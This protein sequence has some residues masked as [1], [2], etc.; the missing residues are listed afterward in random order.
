MKRIALAASFA[1]IVV[2]A[3]APASAQSSATQLKTSH[4]GHA[5]YPQ[6]S[7]DGTSLAYEVLYPADKRREL[8]MVGFSGRSLS[9]DPEK[10]LP[11]SMASSSRYGGSKRVIHGF[12]WATTGNFRYAY[13]VSDNQGTQDIYVDNWS[14]MVESAGAANK[15]ADWD[16]T[17]ARFVF[18]SGRTGKGD[19]YLWDQGSELQLTYDER[20]GELYPK[21]S[22]DGTKVAFVRA[23]ASSSQIM[24]LDVNLFT[25][26]ALVPW[27]DSDST[28]PSFSPD[29]S[30]IA[31]FSNKGTDGVTKF[32]LWVTDA[33]PGGTPRNVG[34]AVKIPTKGAAHWTPDGKGIVAVLDDADKGDPV[35]IFPVDGGAPNCL[36]TGT[37][38]NRDPFLI[39][40]D[41]SWK[42]VYTAQQTTGADLAEWQELYVY[43]IPR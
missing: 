37:R 40:Q 8:F 1:L 18:S 2:A 9:G 6:V 43:D 38:V 39:V 26:M 30:K 41:S 16:P 33:R 23:G 3:A 36:D 25:S 11:E 29:G 24:L 31:F 7:P 5:Q 20:N 27:E 14:A 12:A 19:L 22:P 35:C 32:G 15:N 4:E 28:R 21:F 42:V 34:A 10:L 17:T 13:T